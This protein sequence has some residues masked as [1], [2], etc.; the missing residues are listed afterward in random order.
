MN[1]MRMPGFTA[2]VTL[3]DTRGNHTGI[4]DKNTCTDRSVYPQWSS[5]WLD[6]YLAGGGFWECG[7][8]DVFLR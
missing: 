1:T 6:C 4:A 5:Q 2:E 7:Y 3:N 8:W